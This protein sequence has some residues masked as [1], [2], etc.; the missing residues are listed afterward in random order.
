MRTGVLRGGIAGQASVLER[1]FIAK[2]DI[3]NGW[4][5]LAGFFAGVL[6]G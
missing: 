5:Y 4:R 6:Y 3:S 1:F 2:S